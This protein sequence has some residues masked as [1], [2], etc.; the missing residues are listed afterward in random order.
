MGPVESGFNPPPQSQQYG[1]YHQTGSHYPAG[2]PPGHT[3]GTPPLQQA[4]GA[5]VE[6]GPKTEFFPAAK[7]YMGRIIGQKGVTINDVQK[8]SGCDI[9]INQDVPPGQDCLVTIKGSRQGIEMAKQMLTEVIEI[10]TLYGIVCA[11]S[12]W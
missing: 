1:V 4:Y 8:R 10:G 7:M 9:Q 3:Y 11:C 5:Y 12:F 6:R 2:Q